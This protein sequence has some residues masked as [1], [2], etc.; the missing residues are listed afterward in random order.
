M[1]ITHLE[2]LNI[3]LAIRTWH[4]QWSGKTI[5]VHCD[6]QAVVSILESGRTKDPILAAIGRNI[7]IETAGLRLSI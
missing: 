6:N 3:L 5:L 7:A 4:L 2:I 1:C